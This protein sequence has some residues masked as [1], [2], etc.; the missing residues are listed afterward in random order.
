MINPRLTEL[1]HK[2]VVRRAQVIC[3]CAMGGSAVPTMAFDGAMLPDMSGMPMQPA[4][5]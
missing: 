1:K 4:Y 2:T 3:E 5:F